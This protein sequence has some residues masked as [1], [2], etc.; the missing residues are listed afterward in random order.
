MEKQIAAEQ[1]VELAYWNIRRTLETARQ[2]LTSPHPL[3]GFL[4]ELFEDVDRMEKFL[5]IPNRMD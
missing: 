1:I 2:E 4:N 5:N 3:W